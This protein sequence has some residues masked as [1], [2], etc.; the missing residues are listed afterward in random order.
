MSRFARG[1]V[2]VNLWTMLS[3]P[4]PAFSCVGPFVSLRSDLDRVLTTPIST[5]YRWKDSCH[6]APSQNEAKVGALTHTKRT[7]FTLQPNHSIVKV[8]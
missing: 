2:V 7:N 4:C 1:I 6:A 8:A 3:L 5:L